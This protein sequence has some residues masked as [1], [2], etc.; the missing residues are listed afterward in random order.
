MLLITAVIMILGY[1]II[2]NLNMFQEVII[3]K[4]YFLNKVEEMNA[5]SF[6]NYVWVL[7]ARHNLYYFLNDI[8]NNIQY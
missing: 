4:I 7:S 3:P 8:W 6:S 2:P 5:E 1:K